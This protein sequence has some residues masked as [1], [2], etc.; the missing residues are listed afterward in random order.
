VVEEKPWQ[1]SACLRAGDIVSVAVNFAEKELRDRL[2]A[3]GGKWNP[4]EKVWH[5]YM[6]CSA[7]RNLRKGYWWRKAN[8]GGESRN[9]VW[10]AGNYLL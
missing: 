4:E 1:P 3:A 10:D 6:A 2:K 7:A 8:R 5:V 9:P